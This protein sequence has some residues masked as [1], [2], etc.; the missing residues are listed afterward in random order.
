MKT[1][2]LIVST[3]LAAVVGVASAEGPVNYPD[4][5]PDRATSAVSEK[6]RAQV[7]AELAEARRLGLISYGEVNDK[8]ATPEQEKLIADAGLRA[9]QQQVAAH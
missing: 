2:S 7:K 3:L 4:Q 5:G 8:I 6:T 1:A 9:A